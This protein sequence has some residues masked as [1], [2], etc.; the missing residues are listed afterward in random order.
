MARKRPGRT[1]AGHVSKLAPTYL[2]PFQYH[3]ELGRILGF[4]RSLTLAQN[5]VCCSEYLVLTGMCHMSL[6]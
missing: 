2:I 4:R 6:N 1:R 5:C 3:S